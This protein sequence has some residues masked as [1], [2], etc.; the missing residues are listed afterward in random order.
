MPYPVPPPALP[1]VVN[2]VLPEGSRHSPPELDP[3]KAPTV[4]QAAGFSS[5]CPPEGCETTRLST[6]E[7]SSGS[8]SVEAR[9]EGD[10]TA[11]GLGQPITVGL[12]TS[13][14]PG[15]QVPGSQVPTSQS[16]SIPDTNSV[17]APIPATMG[18]LE[19]D[20]MEQAT[21]TTFFQLP[22]LDALLEARNRPRNRATFHATRSASPSDQSSDS[23]PSPTALEAKDSATT[24]LVA[25]QVTDPQ[26]TDLLTEP[27]Q[28]DSIRL[29]LPVPGSEVTPETPD[30]SEQPQTDPL[31]L[32]FPDRSRPT[33]PTPVPEPTGGEILTIPTRPR[34]ETGTNQDNPSGP[35]SGAGNSPDGTGIPID[36]QAVGEVLEVKGDRQE[37]DQRQQ[38][39]R[40]DGNV[41]IRFRQGLLTADRVRVNIPNRVFVAE[42]NGVLTRGAQ[43]LRGER[44]D[45]NFGL[46]QGSIRTARGEL[47]IPSAGQDFDPEPPIDTGSLAPSQPVT[48]QVSSAQPL[49]VLGGLPGPAFGVSA[50]SGSRSP[51]QGRLN[52]LRF[53]ADSA[54]FDGSDLVAENVRITNDPFS[55]PELELRSSR[56]TYTRLSPFVSEIR[57]RNPRLVF[58]Q[59]FSLPLLVNRIV[60]DNRR[61]NSG[62][63]NFAFD[64]E[65][66]G[67]FYIERSFNLYSSPLVD[68]TLTP[69]ILVQRAIDEGSFPQANQF[70]LVANLDFNF[71]PTTTAQA[72]ANFSSL[73]FSDI[74]DNLRASFRAQQRV[75]NHTVAA[76]YSYRNRLFNGSLGFQT[77]QSSV[78]LVVTSPRYILGNSQINLRYQGSVQ[79][80]NA[81]TDQQD[82]LPPAPNP[83]FP[84]QID[85]DRDLN[86]IDPDDRDTT[87]NG[88]I[89][90]TRY[91]A[92]INLS[93]IFYLWF[94]TALPPTPTEGLRYSPYP[95]TP[96]VGVLLSS[97]GVASGYSSGDSQLSLQGGVTLL[98]QFGHFSKP[99]LDYTAF[100]IG[101]SGT[102]QDGDSPFLFD[103][104]ADQQVL[105]ASLTQ[106]IYGPLRFGVQVSYNLENG[107]DIDTV[108]SL[109]YSRRTYSISASYSTGRQ[110][111]ALTFRLNDFNWTGDPGPFSG[112]GSDAVENGVIRGVN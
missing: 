111:G 17:P 4:A 18:G 52:R 40:V 75:F 67:G 59:G 77:V 41:Q 88:C 26:S 49:Q 64:E 12:P 109:E 23:N 91:Q 108:Y 46:N 13:E 83:L 62:L 33:L 51:Q 50:G 80:I 31:Q 9:L 84:G 35:A 36:P 6:V 5:E 66:R 11:A 94:G 20:R 63:L 55:P 14:L 45:Y 105:S 44:F 21:P 65:D 39:V 7:S 93:R 60:L 69:Q 38:V 100:T 24:N 16:G 106:Q 58:D 47:T 79:Y 90:L 73:D 61:R 53:E 92:A 32:E 34:Q 22:D 19:A 74:G 101:Y 15:L 86:C 103:S 96:Y 81:Q 87:G 56:V 98:G 71:T 76:E 25:E 104:I 95:L 68:F 89:S 54:V 37:F 72:V 2:V 29:D 27:L 42:G 57:A 10:S 85:P 112:L 102:L 1:P 97:Q 107:D 99:F 28:P 70:G 110:A 3:A 78:G 48:Q 43:V 8:S 30:A 82:L